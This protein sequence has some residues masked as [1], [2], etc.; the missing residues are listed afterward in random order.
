MKEFTDADVVPHAGHGG[1]FAGPED[2]ID[3]PLPWQSAGLYETATGYGAKLTS[4][5][6]IHFNGRPH[7]LYVTQHANAGSTW[8]MAR[9]RKIFVI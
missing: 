1:I 5:R 2:L 3:A 9:G 6:K 8:F 4:T 7:R